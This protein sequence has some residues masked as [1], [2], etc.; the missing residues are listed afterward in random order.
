VVAQAE[1]VGAVGAF[2]LEKRCLGE[3]G[4]YFQFYRTELIKSNLKFSREVN[5]TKIK[6]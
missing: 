4:S 6:G 5:K 2:G 3:A 1:P